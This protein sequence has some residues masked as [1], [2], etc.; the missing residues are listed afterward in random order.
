MSN[1]SAAR[2]GTRG[3]DS[4]AAVEHLKTSDPVLGRTVD[5][6]GPFT[7]TLQKAPSTFGALA[8]AI[9]Y[10][11]LNGRAAAVIFSRVRAL[12]SGTADYLEAEH[13]MD[14]SDE[15]LRGAGL[16][17]SKLLSIRDLAEKTLDGTIPTLA[18]A[19]RMDDEALIEHLVQVRGIG[20]WTAQ[21]FL[22]F[23]LGRPDVLPADDYGLRKGFAV[24]FKKKGASRQRHVAEAGRTMG[25]VQIS[26]QLVP[27]AH[28]GEI[29]N[30]C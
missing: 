27:V 21:M 7:F 17:R 2:M 29:M 15:A 4:G 10:Q 9:V 28:G 30:P 16:S 20:R 25:S 8:E 13:L 26:C 11:Q 12:V 23:S 3:F 22:M 19:A 1:R 24:A 6:I 5:Q 18:R 14:I